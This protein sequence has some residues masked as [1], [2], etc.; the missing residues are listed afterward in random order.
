MGV[1]KMNK[2]LSIIIGLLTAICL[3]FGGVNALWSYA[4]ALAESKTNEYTCEIID[5]YYPD[6]VPDDGEEELSHNSLLMTI[7]SSDEGFLIFILL[8]K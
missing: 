7:I 4:T 8:I 5:F 3:T 6:N 1:K 2:S